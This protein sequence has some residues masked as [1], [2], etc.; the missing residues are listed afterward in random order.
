[1]K[2]EGRKRIRERRVQEHSQNDMEHLEEEMANGEKSLWAW[3]WEVQA[4]SGSTV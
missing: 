4:V 2:Q 1:M 3:C